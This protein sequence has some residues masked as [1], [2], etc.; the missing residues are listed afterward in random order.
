MTDEWVG[1]EGVGAALGQQCLL[2]CGWTLGLA[3]GYEYIIMHLCKEGV[4]YKVDFRM[5]EV[6]C[7]YL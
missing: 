2:A 3:G 7:V 4:L 1:A 6:H 5:K